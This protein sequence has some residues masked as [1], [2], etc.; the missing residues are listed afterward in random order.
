MRLPQ[1][2]PKNFVVQLD[3][4]KILL[5]PL[6][7]GPG[8]LDPT[9]LQVLTTSSNSFVAI[10]IP[11]FH[12]TRISCPQQPIQEAVRVLESAT[13]LLTT[14]NA[15]HAEATYYLALA[16]VHAVSPPHARTHLC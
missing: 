1:A 10:A 8:Q 4:A 11:D 6:D 9:H 5:M 13:A 12:H 7:L 2:A 15:Q 14:T 3:L 16:Q